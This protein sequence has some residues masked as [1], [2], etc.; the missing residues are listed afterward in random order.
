MKFVW[1]WVSRKTME[2]KVAS[3]LD[4]IRGIEAKRRASMQEAWDAQWSPLLKQAMSL[5]ATR[6]MDFASFVLHIALDRG[7]M[8]MAAMHNDQKVWEYIGDQASYEFRRQIATLNFS[9]LHR[10]ASENERRY[11]PRM[12]RMDGPI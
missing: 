12:A 9:G 11:A 6:K 7:L 4:R 10:L 2:A 8:E 3:E 1:P 5:S